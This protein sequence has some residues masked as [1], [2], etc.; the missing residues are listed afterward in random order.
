MAEPMKPYEA[1]AA[2]DKKTGEL[3]MLCEPERSHTD[4]MRLCSRRERLARVRITEIV[5]EPKP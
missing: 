4:A 1:L 3:R 5:E 2:V